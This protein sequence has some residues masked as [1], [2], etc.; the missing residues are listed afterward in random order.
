MVASLD[1]GTPDRVAAAVDVLDRTD[2][3]IV[4]HEYGIYG[5]ADGDDVLDVLDALVVPSI[6]V[7]H[8][9]VARPDAAPA[10]GARAGVR[11]RRRGRRDDRAAPATGWSTAS[12]ST[13]SKVAVIPHGATTPLDRRRRRPP[14]RPADRAPA[15]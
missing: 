11:R 15:C 2:V 12:T 7:A 3:A 14:T 13:P 4:Q 8:T 10:V 1:D 6:V 5:G 9:V